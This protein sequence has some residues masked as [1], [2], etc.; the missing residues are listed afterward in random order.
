MSASEGPFTVSVFCSVQWSL[1]RWRMLRFI[2]VWVAY[3]FIIVGLFL[4]IPFLKMV[5]DGC[6]FLK[7]VIHF[8]RLKSYRTEKK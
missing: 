4:N 5:Q 1:S 3:V 2:F 8:K 6:I 7:H